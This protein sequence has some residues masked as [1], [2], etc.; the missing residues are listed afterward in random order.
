[1]IE[2]FRTLFWFASRPSHWAQALELAVRKL[3]T[4]KDGPADYAAAT[5]WAASRAVTVVEA[6][7][8]I[9]MNPPGELPELSAG[10]LQ[11]A[12]ERAERTTVR[13]GGAGDLSLLHA[14]VRL[15]G[16]RRIVESGVAYG[17]SSLAILAALENHIDA[18]LV[19]VD[20]PYPKAG[21]EQFVGIVVPESLRMPWSLIREPDRYGLKKAIALLGGRI[22]L[23]HYDSDKSW[24]G[25]TYAY[26]LLWEALVPGGV[27]ISDDIQDNLAFRAFI[28]KKGVPFAVTVSD[29]KYVGIA[30]KS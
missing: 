1:M 18:R 5:E 29:G 28:E 19:S 13:M 2:K 6:L 27:F 23:C 26:P 17:W 22:D 12:V 4:N 9:G 8:A 14:A 15:S 10:L 21:N 24:W 7:S 20:M 11:D 30:R 25:R 16:A 3:R